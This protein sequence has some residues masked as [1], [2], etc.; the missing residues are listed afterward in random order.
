MG[1]TIR[2]G[3]R[4]SA[5]S[6]VARLPNHAGSVASSARARAPTVG[7]RI[8]RI[9]VP[10]GKPQVGTEQFVALAFAEVFPCGRQGLLDL[11]PQR[12][13][14]A[15]PART[16]DHRAGDEQL[17]ARQTTRR[18]RRRNACIAVSAWVSG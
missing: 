4:P 12:L 13:H 2:S 10:A 5:A 6:S 11:Q 18:R 1:W 3:R 7:R 15:A 9:E 17:P 8:A 16:F 14:V